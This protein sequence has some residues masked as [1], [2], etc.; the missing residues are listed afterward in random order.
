MSSDGA[1][2]AGSTANTDMVA[3]YI[4][5]ESDKASYV[6]MRTVGSIDVERRIKQVKNDILS[7]Q[8]VT[9]SPTPKQLF[10]TRHQRISGTL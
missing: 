9:S 10:S 6:N 1:A 2:A 4:L 8:N 3:I 5:P 7:K